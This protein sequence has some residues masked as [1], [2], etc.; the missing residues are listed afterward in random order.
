MTLCGHEPS[1]RQTTTNVQ[2]GSMSFFK[3]SSSTLLYCV[4]ELELVV[5]RGQSWENGEQISAV[6]RVSETT[7]NL[8]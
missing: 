6:L 3:L 1:S 4:Y 2:H 8:H 7:Q 5:S